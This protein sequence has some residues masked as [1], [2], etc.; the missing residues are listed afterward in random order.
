MLC[1]MK[2]RGLLYED[3]V[4]EIMRSE[5][6][7]KIEMASQSVKLSES[8]TGLIVPICSRHLPTAFSTLL[9]FCAH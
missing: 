2:G 5:T 1:N 6:R 3:E 8:V 4:T 9:P 7:F